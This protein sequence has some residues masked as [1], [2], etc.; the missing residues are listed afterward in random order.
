MMKYQ[1]LENGKWA[2]I[3][4]RT[5]H[6]HDVRAMASYESEDFNVVVS[7][8]VDRTFSVISLVDSKTDNL[9]VLPPVP[10]DRVV[11]LAATSRLLL[12]WSDNEVK[13]WQIDDVNG[14][15]LEGIAKR[16][17]IQMIFNV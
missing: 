10:Q 16:Y 7:G 9:R 2:Q 3:D 12:S 17:L 1:R 8:G 15:D 11:S 6:K 5:Y 4:G 13:V 14:T